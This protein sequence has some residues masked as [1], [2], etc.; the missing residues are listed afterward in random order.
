MKPGK[1]DCE[2]LACM[3]RRAM[4]F[5]AAVVNQFQKNMA[6]RRETALSWA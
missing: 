3:A 4:R 1:E 2:M 5:P 6:R